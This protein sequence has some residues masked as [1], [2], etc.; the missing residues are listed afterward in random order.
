MER[1]EDD[2]YQKNNSNKKRETKNREEE[3]E[4]G[5]RKR[6]P[7]LPWKTTRMMVEDLTRR[8]CISLPREKEELLS[9]K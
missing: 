3:K 7:L 1:R 8:W 2:R 5:R 9:L 4:G 6:I